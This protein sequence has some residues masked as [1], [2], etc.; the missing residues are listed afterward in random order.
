VGGNIHHLKNRVASMNHQHESIAGEVF[1]RL[2]MVF[3]GLL[4]LVPSAH[5]LHVYCS[6]RFFGTHA[7]GTV[8][9]SSSGRALGGRPLLQYRDEQGTIYEFKS[10]AKTHWFKRPVVGETIEIFFDKEAP[11]KAI[12]NNFTYNVFFPLL[13][14]VAGCYCCLKSI[15]FHSSKSKKKEVF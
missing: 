11:N 8:V 13:F 3:I 4:M 14:G 5:K 12:V 10:R 15:W 2:M 1:T 9:H 6:L 7:D